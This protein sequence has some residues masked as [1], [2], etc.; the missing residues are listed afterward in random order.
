[1]I[2]NISTFVSSQSLMNFSWAHKSRRKTGHGK[3]EKKKSVK[4]LKMWVNPNE[5]WKP[6]W[7]S[8]PLLTRTWDQWKELLAGG[9]NE[10]LTPLPTQAIPCS[11]DLIFLINRGALWCVCPDPLHHLWRFQVLCVLGS[12]QVPSPKKTSP[13]HIFCAQKKNKKA[14]QSPRQ[15]HLRTR[16]GGKG[17]MFRGEAL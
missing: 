13:L 16:G 8:Q 4:L 15:L 10:I 1:M 6:G 14:P 3:G 2:F 12:P 5:G 7:I 9:W 17:E 11:H